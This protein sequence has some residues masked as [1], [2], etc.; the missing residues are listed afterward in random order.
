MREREVR[1]ALIERVLSKHGVPGDTRVIPELALCQAEARID[2]AVVNGELA[3]W[4]IKTAFDSLRRLPG[5]VEVYSRVFDRVWLAADVRHIDSALKV[6]P[7]W[8]GVV[9]VSEHSGACRVA[10][11][12]ASR[13]NP[14]V[15]LYS[16][17]R[18]LW[19]EEALAELT[20]LGLDHGLTRAPRRALWERLVEGVPRE[21]SEK[22]LRAHVRE[23]LKRR[24]GWRADEPPL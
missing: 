1:A 23:R 8:W 5:Q 21:M 20:A 11:V 19:R 3:G 17:V 9:R 13:R 7:E 24:E 22:V 14:G 12:R 6:I 10:Q 4:E 15:D 18:L 16:L 2:L